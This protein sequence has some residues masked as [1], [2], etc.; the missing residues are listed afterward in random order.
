MK[1]LIG[2]VSRVEYPGKTQKYCFN[3]RYKTRLV[4]HGVDLIGILPPQNVDHT[5]LQIDEQPDLTENDKEFIRRQI[6][7]CDGIL[8]PGGFKTNKYDR[9]IIDYLIEKDIP[10]L[11]ICLGMQ[12]LS[13]YKREVFQNEKND[14]E[15]V[16][17]NDDNTCTHEIDIVKGTK[18][19]S[20][21]NKE[22]IVVNS[23]HNYHIIPNDNFVNAAFAKD[24]YIEAI[25]MPNKKFIVGVQFHPED[26]DDENAN[27]II[28]SFI[29]ACKK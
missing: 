10:T 12:Q 27:N 4:D 24:G 11:G 29:E 28:N 22:N 5:T 7:L 13:N 9:Y 21:I 18:F 26:M 23:R 20:I 14:S 2:I 1:P 17:V 25:E 8:L 15:I 19:Y 6:D 16:H 3:L